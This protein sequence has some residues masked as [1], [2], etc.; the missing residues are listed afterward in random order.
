[1][2]LHSY[3]SFNSNE[4]ADIARLRRTYKLYRDGLFKTCHYDEAIKLL[5]TGK[6]FDKTNYLPNEEELKYEQQRQRLCSHQSEASSEREE[7]GHEQ[8]QPY[9]SQHTSRAENAREGNGLRSS[10]SE[11]RKRGRPKVNK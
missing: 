7:S 11:V 4:R 2:M 9:I 1:M 5:I 10:G 6:W 8:H 3:Y